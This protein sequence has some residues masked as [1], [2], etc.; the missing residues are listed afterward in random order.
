MKNALLNKINLL[1]VEDDK[2][3]RELLSRAL[4]RVVNNLYVANNGEEGYKLYSEHRPDI[5][6][7]DIK[8]PIMDG[9]EM[10]RLIREIDKHIPIIVISAHSEANN[11]LKA[12]ELGI[13]NYILKPIDKKKLYSMLESNAKIILYEKEKQE[14]Q[15]ILQEVI[16]LQPSIV[17]SSSEKKVLFANQFFLDFFSYDFSLDV[18]NSKSEMV[19]Q[20]L[21]NNKNIILE[22][23]STNNESWIDYI[24]NNPNESLRVR[25]N[26]N[27]EVIYF[28][29]TTKEIF[30]SNE[31]SVIVVLNKTL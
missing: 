17:F 12:I 3:I 22:V 2:S 15:N 5:I 30:S 6:V 31:K 13:T 21:K 4:R 16:N 26:K 27:Q 18:L 29:V 11:F 19:Y 10:S 28:H 9:L 24:I 20:N 1:Y 14:Q 25:I 8:M 7:T 23:N